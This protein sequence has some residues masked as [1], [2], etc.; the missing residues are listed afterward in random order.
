V[1]VAWLSRRWTRRRAETAV[2]AAPADAAGDAERGDSEGGEDSKAGD[3]VVG[4]GAAVPVTGP[5]AP[6]RA[7]QLARQRADLAAA[8]AKR[9]R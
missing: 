1:A 8:R 5:D 3:A 7:A 2:A 4:G 6:E 9:A